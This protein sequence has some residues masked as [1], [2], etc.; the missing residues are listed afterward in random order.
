MLLD[1]LHVDDGRV[2]VKRQKS[3]GWTDIFLETAAVVPTCERDRLER[4]RERRA[5]DVVV[6]CRCKWT[7][8]ECSGLGREVEIGYHHHHLLAVA[9]V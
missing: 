8:I 9:A 6:Y 4:E 5:D 1:S 3:F 2:A 7:P